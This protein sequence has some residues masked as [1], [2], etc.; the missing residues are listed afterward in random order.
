MAH[1]QPNSRPG[2]FDVLYGTAEKIFVGV[3]IALLSATVISLFNIYLS[4]ATMNVRLAAVERQVEQL[5]Q[6][7]NVP[8][9]AFN[10]PSH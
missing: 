2:N 3:S 8:T 4:V 7:K 1:I 9:T 6:A 5:G 10:T